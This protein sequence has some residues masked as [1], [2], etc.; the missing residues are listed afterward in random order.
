MAI[1]EKQRRFVEEYLVD[2]NATQAA[3]RAGYS[4]KSAA[5]IGRQNLIKLEISEAVAQAQAERSKRTAITADRVLQELAAIGFSD[6]R[7]VMTWGAGGVVLRESGEL[8]DGEASLLAEVAETKDGMRV[9]LHSK[10]DALG[11]LGQHLGLFKQQH[12]HTGANG[13]PIQTESLSDLEIARRIAFAL[14]KGAREPEK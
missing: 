1:N 10:L 8:T 14:T 9:K 13:G 2:L 11:K 12:E 7:A 5:E 4:E 6:P 3:I